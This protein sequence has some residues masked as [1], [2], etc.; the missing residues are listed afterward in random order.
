MN[1]DLQELEEQL[2]SFRPR[3][4]SSD[5]RD[6]IAKDLA[7]TGDVQPTGRLRRHFL[8]T[9]MLLAAA[10][11]VI[12]ALGLLWREN[13]ASRVPPGP[14][15]MD[16]PFIA[17]EDSPSEDL[18]PPL[19]PTVRAYQLALADSPDQLDALLD[20]H[21]ALLLPS[22]PELQRPGSLLP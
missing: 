22:T 4:A 13:S 10:A 20:Q 18:P 2:R 12:L 3:P 6:R 21:A 17:G 5:L 7:P 8:R 11:I 16:E 19:R 9:A 1:E 15:P 14:G